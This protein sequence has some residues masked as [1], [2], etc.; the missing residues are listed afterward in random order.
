MVL[1]SM[2]LAA[3]TRQRKEAMKIL[4]SFCP[5]II[6]VKRNCGGGGG[7]IFYKLTNLKSKLSIPAAV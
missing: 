4:V 5:C 6:P 7:A 3:Y 1:S 2:E